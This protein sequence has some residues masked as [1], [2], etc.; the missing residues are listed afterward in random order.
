MISQEHFQLVHDG[1]CAS[2]AMGWIAQEL[3][4]PLAAGMFHRGD[5]PAADD[6][7]SETTAGYCVPA[8]VR[9]HDN[10]NQCGEDKRPA[11]Q[12]LAAEFW[13]RLRGKEY[14]VADYF[15]YLWP[16]IAKRCMK[17]PGTMYWISVGL[18]GLDERSQGR[19]ALGAYVDQEAR[20]RFFDPNVGAY[21]VRPGQTSQFFAAYERVYL[22]EFF[23]VLGDAFAFPV[24]RNNR[25]W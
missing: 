13:L 8:F 22:Q 6:F 2:L 7:I 24:E 10:R 1:A 11:V 20:V 17:Q 14:L 19:H 21:R 18:M 16:E 5:G 15:S 25:G 12:E 3:G 4:V 9:Y 23:S